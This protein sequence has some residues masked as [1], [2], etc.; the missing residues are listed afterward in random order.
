MSTVPPTQS[1]TPLPSS[2]PQLKVDARI[3]RRLGTWLGQGLLQR[4][5]P[6]ELTMLFAALIA[7]TTLL[8]L[9]LPPVAERIVR[10]EML[11]GVHHLIADHHAF[12][13]RWA[14][15]FKL[16]LEVLLAVA[17]GGSVF[18]ASAAAGLRER[19]SQLEL[20][21]QRIMLTEMTSVELALYGIYRKSRY[22]ANVG[23]RTNVFGRAVEIARLQI[24]LYQLSRRMPGMYGRFAIHAFY[25]QFPGGIYG[26]LA[27]GLFLLLC[28]VKVV[29]I[30]L[31]LWPN[32]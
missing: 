24:S 29:Q 1:E 23:G 13:V 6:V 4:R 26:L 2:E 28:C 21:G 22:L 18:A 25:T 17:V 12:L 20:L 3:R 14:A 30:Y 16:T 19:L 8:V 27:C 15:F 9:A 7:V 32:P 10:N 11:S 5:R 31:G